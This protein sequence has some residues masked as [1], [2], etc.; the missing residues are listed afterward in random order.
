M[1][2]DDRS[3]APAGVFACRSLFRPMMIEAA[4]PAARDTDRGHFVATAV[5]SALRVARVILADVSDA[6]MVALDLLRTLDPAL[7]MR[8]S[9]WLNAGPVAPNAGQVGKSLDWLKLVRGIGVCPQ[10]VGRI[11][12]DRMPAPENLRQTLGVTSPE[13]ASRM[14]TGGRSHGQ[15]TTGPNTFV[16]QNHPLPRWRN[17]QRPSSV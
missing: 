2:D 11:H 14:R 8:L 4:T 10:S 13:R 6:Q 12:K 3:G 1:T 7:N 15:P 17:G 5:A 16:S 9:A